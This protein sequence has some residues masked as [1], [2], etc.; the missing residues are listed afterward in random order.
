MSPKNRNKTIFS[1][2]RIITGG[3]TQG[4]H[5]GVREAQLPRIIQPE[6]RMK[7]IFV[8]LKSTFFKSDLFNIQKT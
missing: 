7:S 3:E 2:S 5:K 6:N 8:G 4:E 1:E